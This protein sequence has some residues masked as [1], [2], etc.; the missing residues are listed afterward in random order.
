[1]EV[2]DQGT[3]LVLAKVLSCE[4]V[5]MPSE[6]LREK[7]GE[8]LPGAKGLVRSEEE[9]HLYCEQRVFCTA[10]SP[11]AVLVVILP[12]PVAQ[13]LDALARLEG[14]RAWAAEWLEPCYVHACMYGC[15]YVCM[16][17]CMMDGWMDG[18]MDG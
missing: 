5:P 3:Y 2:E 14:L 4:I 15:M 13:G 17:V 6:N 18:W 7:P 1:M 8:I 10:R 9:D 12:A 11:W 16:Y